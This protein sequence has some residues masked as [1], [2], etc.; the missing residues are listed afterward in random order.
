MMTLQIRMASQIR[1]KLSFVLNFQP[2]FDEE[3]LTKL[4]FPLSKQ[5]QIFRDYL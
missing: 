1:V 3:A 2:I 4:K 5:L